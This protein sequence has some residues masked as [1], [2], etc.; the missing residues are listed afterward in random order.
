MARSS[1]YV[2]CS[3]MTPFFTTAIMLEW[4]IV[5]SRCAMVTDVKEERCMML[6]SDSCTT[7]S[8]A[9][10]SA[11]VASSSSKTAGCLMMARAMAT[12]CFWPPESLPPPSPTWVSKPSLRFCVMKS[13]AFAV[14]AAASISSRVAPGLP[15]AIFSA[16][17]PRKSIGSCATRPI[18]AR[19]ALTLYSF[20]LTPSSRMAPESGS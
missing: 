1:S 13:N 10:S 6:S 16:T 12:R 4:R 19:S 3:T 2:P 11:E 20:R 9:L 5:V 15:S 8:E 18:F 7:F 14:R 17:V